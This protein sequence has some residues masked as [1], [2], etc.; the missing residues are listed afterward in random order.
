MLHKRGRR[1]VNKTLIYFT[2]IRLKIQY[3]NVD[4]ITRS[5]PPYNYS[6]RNTFKNINPAENPNG[7]A[8]THRG[9]LPT[10]GLTCAYITLH[11]RC[12]FKKYI[13]LVFS[14]TPLPTGV[15]LTPGCFIALPRSSRQ[16]VCGVVLNVMLPKLHPIQT[17]PRAKFSIYFSTNYV[18]FGQLI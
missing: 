13:G 9:R 14:T 17:S 5:K 12:S 8:L 6:A 2:R 11:C 4:R 3:K 16:I 7:C 10:A 15:E 18:L 1:Y